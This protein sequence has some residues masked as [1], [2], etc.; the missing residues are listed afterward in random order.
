MISYLI[1]ALATWRISSLLVNEFGPYKILERLRFWLGVRYDEDLNR[2]GNNEF[3]ELF[4]CIWCLSVWVGL[5][6][7][8]AFWLLPNL[9]TWLAMPFAFSAV[10]ILIDKAVNRG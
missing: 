7:T 2:H 10:A 5:A 4:T 9:T 6:M 1:L 3:A 8:M